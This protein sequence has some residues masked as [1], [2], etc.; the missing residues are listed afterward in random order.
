MDSSLIGEKGAEKVH[1]VILP[2]RSAREPETNAQHVT[3]STAQR[4]FPPGS[5]WLYLRLSGSIE[6][7]DRAVIPQ[8]PPLVDRFAQMGWIDSWH[9]L[10]YGEPSFHVRLRMH[11]D[12]AL[13]SAHVYPEA[14]AALGPVADLLEI[15]A[16]SRELE[17]YGGDL[18]ILI[19]ESVFHLDSEFALGTHSN[20]ISRNASTA[21]RWLLAHA[22]CW[23]VLVAANWPEPRVSAVLAEAVSWASLSR[24]GVLDWR[25]VAQ[26]F[27]ARQGEL[28]AAVQPDPNREGTIRESSSLKRRR[29]LMSPLIG[30]LEEKLRPDKVDQVIIDFMHLSINRLLPWID[31]GQERAIYW[32]LHRLMGSVGSAQT[33]RLSGK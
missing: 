20:L 18:G 3:R 32:N 9:F 24:G 25:S 17:R 31:W 8:L 29:E 28:L 10:R 6:K 13:L 14:V 23:D 15:G 30:S 12:P 2:V 1:E 4:D 26:A 21:D 33:P 11:G 19:A 16:Y 22:A 7:V 27:R 5:E